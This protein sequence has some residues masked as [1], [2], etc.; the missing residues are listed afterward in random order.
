MNDANTAIVLAAG[1]SRRM[2]EL[3]ADRPKSLLPYKDRPILDRLLSQIATTSID[4]VVIVVGYQHAAIEQLVRGR[5]APRITVVRNARFADDTNIE[6]MRLAL[7][8]VTGSVVIFE[9]D[10]IMEDAMVRYVAGTD[11]EHQSAWF[12]RG[13]FVPPMSGGIVHS[14]PRG[15]IDDVRVV[16][17]WDAA[18]ADYRK[19]TGLMRVSGRELPVFR[20]LVER[21]AERS[22]A[23][24]FFV[25][26]AEHIARLPSIEG[27]GSHYAFKTFNTPDD[28]A[29]VRAMEFDPP[30][31]RAERIEYASPAELLHIEGFDEA[32]VLELRAKIE[33]EARWTKP[34]YVERTHGLVL[35]GQHRLQV[36]RRMGLA[37]VPVQRFD[38]R[39]V[40]VWTL[41]KD[42]P[43]DVDTVI[44]RA[45]AGD[46]YPYK[47]VKHKFPRVIDDCDLP[48]A[49]LRR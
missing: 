12:T 48:L 14:D 27:D 17:A 30:P 29:E 5:G 41:R 3:T 40:A 25:P 20:E 26:W 19:M 22:I 38:Y 28:Y 36:A 35:D 18:Y 7:R 16:P 37:R 2:G 34:L 33:R 10:T 46:L 13:A 6:S 1:S 47:T 43:V 15:Q 49:E 8:E 24:Y 45:T 21:Y 23:Q 42:H 9:A 44:R 31:A 11:F 39:D 4:H 32:R